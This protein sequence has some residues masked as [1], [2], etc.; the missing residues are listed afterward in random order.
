MHCTRKFYRCSLCGN[1][2]GLIEDGGGPLVCCGKPMDELVANAVDASG[3]KHVPVLAEED[4]K[5]VVKI[6]AAPHPMTEEHSIRWVYVCTDDG[7][8]R[9]QLNPGDPPQVALC[10]CAGEIRAVYAYCN[11]HGLWKADLP[12]TA[13]CGCCC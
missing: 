9:Y 12:E 6:G 3:E 13:G 1:L 10:G 11:L 4:G 2:V 5:A 8:H 7:G